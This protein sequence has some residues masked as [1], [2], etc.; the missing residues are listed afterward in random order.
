[1]KKNLL[2]IAS[3]VSLSAGAQQL[4]NA[5]FETWVDQFFYEDPSEWA[6]LNVLS[7]FGAPVSVTKSTDFHEGSFSAKLETT[8][9]DVD[10]DGNDDIVP[11]L[12]FNGYIDFATQSFVAGTPFNY[13][14]D[15]LIGWTKYSP[16]TGD[17]FLIQAQLTKWD[18]MIGDRTIIGEGFYTS[19]VSSS[20]FTSF[21]IDFF[22]ELTDSPD[23]ISVYV[24]NTNPNAPVQGSILWVDDFSLDYTSSVGL[25]ETEN[26]YFKIYPNPATDE[27]RLRADK[28]EVVKI[29]S[30]NGQEVATVSINKGVEKIISCENLESGMYLLQRQNGK[31]IKFNIVK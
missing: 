14:P 18:D 10:Q 17:A 1:M 16:T 11:G 29:L 19:D 30:L 3:I 20:S 7:S 31:T 23:T 4:P 15:A 24:F 12:M 5:G 27:L 8:V 22:Y 13:R 25:N 6:T 28:D 9:F 21:Q 2:L 26:D